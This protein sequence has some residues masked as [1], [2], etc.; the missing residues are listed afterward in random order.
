MKAR[1]PPHFVFPRRYFRRRAASL[2]PVPAYQ[3]HQFDAAEFAEICA[4]LE[5]RRLRPVTISELLTSR[6][7]GDRAVVLSADDGWSSVWSIA[8]PLARR[9]GVRFTIFIPPMA[10]EDSDE[11]RPGLDDGVAA[12]E[13]EARDHGAHP[14]LTWGEVLAM[15]RSGLVD[16]QSHSS[17]HGVVFVSG[18]L[19]GF[20][21]PDGP[22]P[23]DGHVPL[24]TREATGDAVRF[25]VA[26]GTPLYAHGRALAAPVRYI[27]DLGARDRCVET[28][29]VQGGSR[30]F[31]ANGWEAR[32]R[33]VHGSADGGRPET[34]EE[35]RSRI[36]DDLL[37]SKRQIEARLGEGTVRVLAPPWAEMHPDVPGI[38]RE[39]GYELIVLGYPF[40]PTAREP[41]LPCYPRLFGD[42]V[43]THIDGPIKGTVA[44][45]RHRRRAIAR[46]AAGGIP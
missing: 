35:R 40:K 37:D 44:W 31:E 13:L 14:F 6:P 24:M 42:A 46:V 4:A 18:E 29:H 12:G 2:S 16:V 1:W 26:P 10:I 3:Y 5:A 17:H 41:A 21:R 23:V 34:D 28:V 25:H 33:D 32:L 15:H 38:A 11:C 7:L 39:V 30:F 45:Q 27:E 20:A 36:N 19:V 8:F 43:W 22:F 9:H